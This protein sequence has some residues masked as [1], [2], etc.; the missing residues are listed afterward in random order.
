MMNKKRIIPSK[1]E[2]PAKRGHGM[3]FPPTAQT[4]LNVDLLQHALNVA[5]QDYYT[6]NAN[7]MRKK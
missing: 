1:L 7:L 5:S 6:R 4:A 2:N 3:P